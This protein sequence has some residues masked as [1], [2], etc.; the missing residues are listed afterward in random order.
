MAEQYKTSYS[1]SIE[2]YQYK[3]RRLWR[4]GKIKRLR[5]VGLGCGRNLGTQEYRRRVTWRA[6]PWKINTGLQPKKQL[7]L[8]IDVC[9]E[10]VTYLDW[11][12]LYF[13]IST[14]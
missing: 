3:H 14:V 5:S 4:P 10:K 11:N 8:Q 2:V 7:D 1:S 9:L 12:L 6:V 13:H